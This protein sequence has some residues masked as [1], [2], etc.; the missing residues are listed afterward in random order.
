MVEGKSDPQITGFKFQIGDVLVIPENATRFGVMGQ[1]S[2]AGYYPVP[3]KATDATVLKALSE[4]G[5]QNQA[6]LKDASIIRT[7]NGAATRIPV[8]I[9]AMLGKGNLAGNIVLQPGDI[10]YLPPKGAKGTSWLQY[11]PLL[12]M[13]L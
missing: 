10:L 11:I 5:G 8:N 2:R 6:N 1:V 7:V 13:F 9:E 3:D 12:G 4:A